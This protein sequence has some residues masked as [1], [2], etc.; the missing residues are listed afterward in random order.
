MKYSILSS[1]VFMQM[2][3]RKLLVRAKLTCDFVLGSFL[4]RQ[5]HCC[6]KP[7]DVDSCISLS[8]TCL[9]LQRVLRQEG[10]TFLFIMI[11]LKKIAFY[12]YFV[13]EKKIR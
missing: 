10:K 6:S 4:L 1:A 11:L 12:Y 2:L 13:K 9:D 3:Q 5:L 8:I 7:R